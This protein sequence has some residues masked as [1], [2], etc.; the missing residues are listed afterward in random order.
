MERE[1]D[2]LRDVVAELRE[3][4]AAQARLIASM[5]G[6]QFP[7]TDGLFKARVEA[8]AVAAVDEPVNVEKAAQDTLD[9]M[10]A[11]KLSRG[12]TEKLRDTAVES[13]RKGDRDASVGRAIGVRFG[14]GLRQPW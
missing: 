11:R 1:I 8:S 6:D 12:M 3:Q 14:G 2:R 9:A 4:N 13:L 7:D 10:V 5:S